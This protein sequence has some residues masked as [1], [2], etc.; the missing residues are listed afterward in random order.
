[1]GIRV[2]NKLIRDRIPRIIKDAGEKPVVKTL[3]APA[4]R[5]ALYQKLQEET[6]EYLRSGEQEELAD[7]L[8]VVYALAALDGATPEELEIA[9]LRKRERNGGFSQRLYLESVISD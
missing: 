6:D 4:Y 8:E 3:D 7:I 2:Y 1:M 5:E 9:R